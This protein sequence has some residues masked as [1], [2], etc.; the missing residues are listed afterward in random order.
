MTTII[1]ITPN[2][3]TVTDDTLPPSRPLYHPARCPVCKQLTDEEYDVW[4]FA[5]W[6]KHGVTR[7]KIPTHPECVHSAGGVWVRDSEENQQYAY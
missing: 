1:D 7:V 6:I 3:Y 4:V 2:G 5:S